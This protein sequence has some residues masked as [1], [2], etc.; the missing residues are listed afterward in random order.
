MFGYNQSPIGEWCVQLSDPIPYNRPKSQISI[1]NCSIVVIKY[2]I[3]QHQLYHNKVNFIA[4]VS[5]LHKEQSPITTHHITNYI[6]R[7]DR[8]KRYAAS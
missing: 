4:I 1:I 6:T 7:Q 8:E 2:V 5:I 3:I